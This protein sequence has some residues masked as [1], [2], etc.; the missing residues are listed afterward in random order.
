MNTESSY[1]WKSKQWTVPVN[2]TVSH[3]VELGQQRVSLQMGARYYVEAPSS[4]PDWGTRFAL[5]FLFPK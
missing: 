3:M 4:G 2:I 1:N 5:V